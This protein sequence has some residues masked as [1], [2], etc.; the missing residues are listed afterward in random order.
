M[1]KT[2]T[3]LWLITIMQ[4]IHKKYTYNIHTKKKEWQCLWFRE[5][6]NVLELW[7]RKGPLTASLTVA[8]APE[9]HTLTSSFSVLSLPGSTLDGDFCSGIPAR[10]PERLWLSSSEIE[11]LINAPS[12]WLGIKK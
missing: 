12:D 1:A 8:M 4:K 6:G 5:T 7:H 9:S 3:R 2:E 11:R 10:T